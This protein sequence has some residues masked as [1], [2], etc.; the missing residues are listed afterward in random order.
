MIIRHNGKQTMPAAISISKL[1]S[2]LKASCKNEKIQSSS[3]EKSGSIDEYYQKRINFLEHDLIKEASV[4]DSLVL[5]EDD[6]DRKIEALRRFLKRI[7]RLYSLDNEEETESLIE[8]VL[9]AF[10]I[11][12]LTVLAQQ[13]LQNS[14]KELI[15]KQV[16]SYI[17]EF[18]KTDGISRPNSPVV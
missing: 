17:E 11:G 14:T 16:E 1:I 4:F 5:D 12:F 2:D 9:R 6:S 7:R 8:T 10:F 18:K 3:K 13:K 15:D